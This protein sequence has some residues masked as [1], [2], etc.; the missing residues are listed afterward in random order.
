VP[1]ID[2]PYPAFAATTGPTKTD[3][4]VVQPGGVNLE[5]ALHS[6]AFMIVQS[7]IACASS[8]IYTDKMNESGPVGLR[9]LAKTT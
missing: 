9:W 5:G 1:Y 3:N 7:V 6:N 4:Q 2:F 8:G